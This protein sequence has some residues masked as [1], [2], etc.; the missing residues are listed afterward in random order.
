MTDK[1][2]KKEGQSTT[3]EAKVRQPRRFSIVWLIP[4]VTVA[5]AGWIGY[6]TIS[7]EGPKIHITFETAEG[8]EAGKTKVMFKGIQVGTVQTIHAN[9]DLSHIVV[10]AEMVKEAKSHL[11]EGTKFWVV[12]PQV[13]LERISGLGTLV[14]GAYIAFEPGSGKPTSTFEGLKEPPISESEGRKFTLEAPQLGS[15]HVSAPVYYHGISV[16]EVLD[17]ELAKND[18]DVVI[19]IL[20][21]KPYVD[22]VHTNSVFW[23]VS[24]VKLK[25]GDLVDASV[26]I[27]S[28]ESLVA[29]GIAFDNPLEAGPQA[30]PDTHYR[31]LS[32]PPEELSLTKETKKALSIVLK[33]EVQ[34]SVKADDPILYREVQVGTVTEVGLSEDASYV[35]LQVAIEPRYAPLVRDKSVFWNASGIHAS[36][37]LFS[38]A[39][40]DVESL[41]ALLRGGIAFA[42]PQDGGGVAKTGAIFELHPEPKKEW[43]AWAPHIRLPKEPPKAAQVDAATAEAGS[44]ATLSAPA[45]PGTPKSDTMVDN[46]GSAADQTAATPSGATADLPTALPISGE[47]LSTEEVSEALGKI[48]FTNIGTIHKS[49]S[50]V[51]TEADWE[52]ETVTLRIDTRTARIESTE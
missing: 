43:Q 16:G 36:F 48:G 5:V 4:L 15:I 20:I 35:A 47:N 42:T 10:T 39:D 50:I 51:H 52:G 33:S 3:P 12:R 25:L 38:G 9:K 45:K 11:T 24:G 17:Y 30:D 23:N 41:S 13:S 22:L 2:G 19:H 34:G 6:R 18:K 26:N 37:G 27:Q 28:L 31:L 21:D 1:S 29:G 44:D 14:S 8:L 7:D 32:G 49:G 40:I 46:G